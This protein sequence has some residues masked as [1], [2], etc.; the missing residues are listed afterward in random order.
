MHDVHIMYI[1]FCINH[2]GLP[3]LIVNRTKQNLKKYFKGPTI[4][5]FDNYNFSSTE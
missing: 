4:E 5:M 1:L 2:K 3:Y